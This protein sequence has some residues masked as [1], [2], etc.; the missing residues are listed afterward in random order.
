MKKRYFLVTG[1][2]GFIGAALVRRLVK[3]GHK[4]RVLDNL[5]RGSA[6]RLDPVAGDVDF[7]EA[8]IRDA[9][10]V[11]KAH[12]GVDSVCHLAFVNGTEFFYTKPD[13]VMDV[14]V[15]GMVNV[16]DACREQG[17]RELILASPTA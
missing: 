12:A 17:V 5:S 11:R 10:A 9:G 8:D 6:K 3:D 2:A 13:F 14:G 1:G 4:V 15:K 7:I 16:I